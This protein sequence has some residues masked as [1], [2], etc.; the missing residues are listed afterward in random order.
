MP[1]AILAALACLVPWVGH[2]QESGRPARV[3]YLAATPLSS[4]QASAPDAYFEV[5][6]AQLATHGFASGR[7]LEMRY[8]SQPAD[9]TDWS[10]PWRED[11]TRQ[12]ANW[13]PDVMVV[14]TSI[15]ARAAR[16]ANSSIPIVFAL[17]QDA[18]TEGLVDAL[19][20]PGANMTGATID[21]DRLALK[22]L[23]IVR[24]VLPKARR[25]VIVWDRRGGGIPASLRGSMGKAAERLG[26]SIREIDV[27][28]VEGG[29]CNSGAQV[30]EAHA[31]A[32][33]PLGNIFTEFKKKKGVWV[34]GY[35]DCL[36]Q[37]QSKSRIP[38]VDDS[39]DTVESGV[40]IALGEPTDESFRRAADV[41]ARVLRGTKP[42]AI[43]VDVQMRVQLWVNSTA[44]R[45]LGLAF[46]R[47]FLLRAD[48]I[49][50]QIAQ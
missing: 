29:L 34:D 9:R 38:V 18:E 5:I 4:G 15:F 45:D 10:G 48:K 35:G 7:N 3:A 41:V 46:S 19:P 24:E 50:T 43:P 16:K 37:L 42:G 36:Y 8:F 49:V 6:K 20:K 2:A 40:A 33:L 31:E 14:S 30:V 25:I 11:L 39:V 21:Y 1:R 44:G 23:E 13:K 26:F 28:D 27:A 12:A 32:I 22:R 17:V 47:P